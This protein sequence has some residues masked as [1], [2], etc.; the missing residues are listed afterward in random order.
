MFT[1]YGSLYSKY[2]HNMRRSTTIPAIRGRL[3]GGIQRYIRQPGY[4]AG[5][6]HGPPRTAL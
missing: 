2:V 6:I 5:L 4:V 3:E 1:K